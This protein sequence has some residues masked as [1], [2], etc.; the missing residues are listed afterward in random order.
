MDFLGS[1]EVSVAYQCGGLGSCYKGEM[2]HLGCG[3][4]LMR[5]PSSSPVYRTWYASSSLTSNVPV[6]SLDP[7][8]CSATAQRVNP[9]ICGA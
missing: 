9:K 7:M 2:A 8:A 1:E 4:G 5:R 3:G 6:V